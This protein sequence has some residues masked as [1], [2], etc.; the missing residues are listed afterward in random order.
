MG[1]DTNWASIIEAGVLSL[2]ESIILVSQEGIRFPV[3]EQVCKACTPYF[4]GLLEN[5]MIEAGKSCLFYILIL[6][7]RPLNHALRM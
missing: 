7:E 3:K 4:E 1:D 5:G 2:D 6:R